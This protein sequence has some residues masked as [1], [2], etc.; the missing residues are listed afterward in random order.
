MIQTTRTNNVNYYYCFW[1]RNFMEL[2]FRPCCFI[3]YFFF[4]ICHFEYSMY[5]CTW[6]KVGI[7]PPCWRKIYFWAYG[8]YFRFVRGFV[9]DLCAKY[10]KTLVRCAY[11]VRCVYTLDAK[12]MPSFLFV[13]LSLFDFE[14]IFEICVVD[15]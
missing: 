15:V 6:M 4:T 13:H 8:F 1:M 11:V 5:V 14:S 2:S 9:L 10:Y 7:E 3:D 12:I